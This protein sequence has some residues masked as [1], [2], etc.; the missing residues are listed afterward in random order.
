MV[1]FPQLMFFVLIYLGATSII[2]AQIEENDGADRIA[3]ISISGLKRTK[4]STAERPLRRFIGRET[5]GLEADEVRA[6]VLDT[7]VLEPVSIEINGQTLSVTVR[8]KWAIFP[9]PVFMISSGGIL[10]GLAFYDANAFGLADNFFLAGLY[11]TGGWSAAA[12]YIHNSQ[13]GRLPGWNGMATYTR[14][15]R[16]DS[17]QNNADLRR[18]NQDS[19]SVNTGINIPLIKDTDLLSASAL[20][21][22][23]GRFLRKSGKTLNAPEGDLMLFGAGTELGARRSSWD[24]FLLSEESASVRYFYRISPDGFSYHSVRFRGVWEKSLVPGFRVNIKTG[25][26][27]EPEV[28][29]LFESSPSV[30]QVAI[31]P[32][33]FSA[34][35]YAGISA[36]LEKYI[37]KFRAGTISLQAAYQLVYSSGS[38]LGDSVDHGI[39]GLLVFYLN[40]IAIPALGLGIAYNVRGNYLQGSFALG[41]QF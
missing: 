5:D 21:S 9:V 1:K 37:Y 4:L 3:S 25:A 11:Q 7:G 2:T 26:L 22:Y 30:S 12:G 8:E 20:A 18:F 24:G 40:R 10:A 16:H 35:N 36:G 6:A 33:D 14:E 13:G 41:M 31:L 34:M 29:V 19:I 23:G 17:N 32:G 38:I 39:L 27:F 28:P 15:E